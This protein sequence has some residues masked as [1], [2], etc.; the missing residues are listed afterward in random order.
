[1]PEAA[2]PSAADR[3]RFPSGIPYIVGNEG[4]ERFSYYGMRAILYVY[5]ASLFVRFVNEGDVPPEEMAA[6]KARSTEIAHLFMA[7]VYAFPLIGAILADRLLGKFN[8]IFWVSL[9]YCA[10]HGVLAVAGRLGEMGS[11][12]GA[13]VCMYIGLGL[14]TTGTPV[15]A[16]ITATVSGGPPID[17]LGTRLTNG[18]PADISIP[19]IQSPTVVAGG[20]GYRIDV[21]SGASRLREA[22]PRQSSKKVRAADSRR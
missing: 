14:I 6:A 12:G 15:T 7:G 11:Y 1:M 5:L 17:P 22:Q 21:P 8:V 9:I 18:V 3:D 10:G 4:A 13:E 19:A 20:L 2:S 16:R